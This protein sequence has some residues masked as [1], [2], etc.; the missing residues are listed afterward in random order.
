[1]SHELWYIT[2]NMMTNITPIVGTTTRR[3]NINELGE[4][5]DFDIAFNDA[6]FFPKNP[7]DIGS[8]VLLK[9]GEKE[10]V[11]AIAIKEQKT[12][13]NVQYN[14]FD[15]A[16]Y[17]N[18]SKA[19]YQF[20]KMKADQ[21]IKKI[22]GDFS[23]SIGKICS[24]PYPVTKIYSGDVVSEIIKDILDMAEKAIGTKYRMEMRLGKLY[25]EP[26]KDLVISPTFRIASNIAPA[27][28]ANTISNPQRTRSIEEMRNSIKL[29]TGNEEK[30]RVVANVK[31][32]TLI[33]QY[34]LLQ[35]VISIEDKDIAQANRIAQNMLKELGKV[36]EENG[37]E[38]I[39]H[40]DVRAGRIIPIEEPLTGMTGK[41]L[42]TDANHTI[43]NGIHTVKVGLEA[44]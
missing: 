29:I 34:G 36:F 14:C 39:G 32:D 9:N 2:G 15:Y 31:N 11:R 7:V 44:V 41:Y 18:K 26:Q 16:F 20:T 43:K 37:L 28:I 40:D 23:I 17:L 3:S 24:I 27:P 5:L 1:M 6:R 8:L 30:M 35:E 4:Q 25:I 22:L 42:I 19:V 12:A 10:V 13:L 38:M 33:K 21:A